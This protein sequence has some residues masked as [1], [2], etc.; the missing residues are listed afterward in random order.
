MRPH[1]LHAITGRAQDRQESGTENQT[2]IRT[3][4]LDWKSLEYFWDPSLGDKTTDRHIH[5]PTIIG[6]VAAL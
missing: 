6:G 1:A 3:Y 4:K 5:V 2:D